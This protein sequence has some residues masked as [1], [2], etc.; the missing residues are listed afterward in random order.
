MSRPTLVDI[1]SRSAPMADK[2]KLKKWVQG[3]T[4]NA[5]GQFRRKAEAAGETTR[6]FAR[7]KADAPG[8]LGKQARLAETLMGLPHAKKRLRDTYKKRD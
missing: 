5:H 3:A 7:E 8:L 1:A 6:E 4:E 2:P